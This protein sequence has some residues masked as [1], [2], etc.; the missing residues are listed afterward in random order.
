MTPPKITGTSASYKDYY[1]EKNI[2]SFVLEYEW[3]A[4]Q[5]FGRLGLNIGT[6]FASVKGNGFFKKSGTPAE[7]TYTMY[8]FPLSA[9]LVYR[10][11]Y[12]RRQWVVPFVNG[13]G[14]LYG[15]AEVRDDNK[16][17]SAMGSAVGGGGGLL[18]SIS[19]IDNRAAFILDRE[20]GIADLYF[21]LEARAMQ[22]VS[23]QI[24]FTHQSVNGGITVDF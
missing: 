3:Q 1:G 9:F 18:F 24:D 13:G 16:I 17:N 7:E 19:A 21:S 8:T 2:N 22:G 6:G 4:F 12:M 10:F 23:K 15:L 11:E 5:S 14:S 20:Y